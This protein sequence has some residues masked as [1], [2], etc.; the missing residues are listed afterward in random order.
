MVFVLELLRAVLEAPRDENPSLRRS[1]DFF[2]G[3]F[4]F[5]SFLRRFFDFNRRFPDDGL[6]LFGSFAPSQDFFK[7]KRRVL[8]AH[9][10]R[11]EGIDL[12]GFM[13]G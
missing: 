6:L 3:D 1:F 12:R 13:I 5:D 11:R 10:N 8:D 7:G 2:D 9:T 4:L